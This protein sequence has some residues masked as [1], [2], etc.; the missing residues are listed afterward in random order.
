M[1]QQAGLNSEGKLSIKTS[2]GEDQAEQQGAHMKTKMKIPM[3]LM[4]EKSKNQ[5]LMSCGHTE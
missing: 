5:I 4:Y 1:G 3:F 2:N